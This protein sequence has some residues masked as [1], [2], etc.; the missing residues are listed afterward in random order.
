MEIQKV[1][2][3]VVT[4]D[5]CGDHSYFLEGT[6][7]DPEE[8]FKNLGWLSVEDEEGTINLCPKCL[9]IH[10]RISGEK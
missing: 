8:E 2:F 4:C 7:E 1:S 10:K 3:D 9:K 5:L 6:V